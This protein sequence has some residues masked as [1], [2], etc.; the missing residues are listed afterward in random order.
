[1]HNVRPVPRDSHHVPTAHATTSAKSDGSAVD[2]CASK[3]SIETALYT[4]IVNK[5]EDVDIPSASWVGRKVDAIFSPVLSFLQNTSGDCSNE[6]KLGRSLAQPMLEELGSSTHSSED[7]Y[8]NAADVSSLVREALSQVRFPVLSEILYPV[9]L[10]GNR[11][12]S[13][14]W[15]SPL[16]R[17]RAM[18]TKMG[19]GV[20]S[21]L[22]AF[23]PRPTRILRKF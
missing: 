14:S 4:N 16:F 17:L 7:S 22:M 15:G 6:G 8:D 11:N 9:R 3:L 10:A 20:P 12:S 5:D 2:A 19:I 1:M 13:M 18:R 23:Q 21:Q